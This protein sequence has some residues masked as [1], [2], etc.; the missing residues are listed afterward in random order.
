VLAGERVAANGRPLT[1]GGVSRDK[2]SSPSTWVG[3]SRTGPARA[4]A[5]PASSGS[6][7]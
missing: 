2:C 3:W 4:Q 5:T 1:R 7:W 6:V